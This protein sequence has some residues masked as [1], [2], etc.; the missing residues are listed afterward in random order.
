MFVVI[1]SA[2]NGKD[3]NKIPKKGEVPVYDTAGVEVGKAKFEATQDHLTADLYITGGEPDIF[4]E[5]SVTTD[6]DVIVLKPILLLRRTDAK[7]R[8]HETITYGIAV[9]T[10]SFEATLTAYESTIPIWTAGPVTLSP[11]AK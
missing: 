10:E 3:K 4:F 7:G 9:K 8:T 5:M 11:K 2:A 6:P 1:C